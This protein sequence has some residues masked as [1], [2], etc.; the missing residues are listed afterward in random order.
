M[1]KKT[2]LFW[3]LTLTAGSLSTPALAAD[4]VTLARNGVMHAVILL[5]KQAHALEKQAAKELAEHLHA[6]TGVRPET[7]TEALTPTAAAQAPIRLGTVRDEH[8]KALLQ[9]GARH[10]SFALVVSNDSITIGGL[11]PVGTLYGAYELLE[12]LGVRWYMPGKLGTVLPATDRLTLTNQETL[13]TPSFGTRAVGG[14]ARRWRQRLR[15]GGRGPASRL[16]FPDPAPFAEHPEYYALVDG[17]R[18]RRQLCVSNPGALEAEIQVIRAYFAERPEATWAPVSNH[19]VG[20]CQC[21]NCRALDPPDKSNRAFT[22]G[23]NVSDRYVWFCNRILAAIA[24]DL[25]EKRLVMTICTPY[26]DAPVRAKGDP[27]LDVLAWPNGACRLHG[28]NNPVCPGRTRVLGTIRQWIEMLQGD[29]Y[30]RGNW[31]NIAGPGLLLPAVHRYR[32]DIPDYHAAGVKGFRTTDYD[33][34]I[35]QTPS[36]Y[37]GAKLLWNHKADVDAILTEFYKLFYGPAAS[38]MRAYHE[39]LEST[40]RDANHHTG[41]AIDFPRIYPQLVRRKARGFLERAVALAPAATYADRLKATELGLA[42][43]D[44]FCAMIADRDR[45][46]FD[47]AQASLKEAHTLIRTLQTDYKPPLLNPSFA[48]PYLDRFF[49]KSI[50]EAHRKGYVE[51]KSI[52]VLQPEWA[53]RLD[54][55][56]VGEARGWWKVDVP[57]DGWTPQQTWTSSWSN[58][59]LHNHEGIA[60]YRQTFSLPERTGKHRLMLWF[61]GVDETAKVWLNGHL[62][63]EHTGA[64]KTFEF[65][66]SGAAKPGRENTVVAKIGNHTLDEVGTGGLLAPVFVYVAK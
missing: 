53:Y 19:G 63:G 14:P 10:G 7:T 28:V 57:A 51:G 40:M 36:S 8:R 56:A 65:D 25:P 24:K 62:L 44:A 6:I 1:M 3:T 59:G 16:N 41:S 48:R 54:P 29:Y 4:E 17:K 20:H 38:P 13:Q 39:L 26:F 33:H 22:G 46:R 11:G 50:A 35:S 58:E 12:Q 60:W 64:F 30:E 9:R 5:P 27:R 2:L 34:R 21:D 61:G 43:L 47:L 42:Y 31:G 37:V 55:T 15:L 45:G 66:I 18:Q 49:G 32:R 52:R 23:V